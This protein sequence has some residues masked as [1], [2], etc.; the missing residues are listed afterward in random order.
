MRIASVVDW[1]RTTPA[2][3]KRTPGS[4]RA[5]MPEVLRQW[6]FANFYAI[7][8]A[9]TPGGVAPGVPERRRRRRRRQRHGAGRRPWEG[10]MLGVLGRWNLVGWSGFF[11]L[12][13]RL[14]FVPEGTGFTEILC[15]KAL[16][17][18]IFRGGRQSRRRQ[19]RDEN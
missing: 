14:G 7:P 16:S 3:R 11:V 6:D 9:L 15:R 13:A 1:R 10:A 17:E 2:D 12:S 5:S 19:L 18:C 8:S 4:R